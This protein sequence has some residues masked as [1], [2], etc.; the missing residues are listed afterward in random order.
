MKVE[1]SCE[2]DDA[3]YLEEHDE[4]LYFAIRSRSRVKKD[5]A[6][7]KR[8]MIRKNANWSSGGGIRRPS[9]RT[10]RKMWMRLLRFLTTS[11]IQDEMERSIPHSGSTGIYGKRQEK[12]L[13]QKL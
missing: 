10:P 7:L 4:S 12:Y 3:V 1:K 11:G 2:M 9:G 6:V 8:A 5:V 13:G